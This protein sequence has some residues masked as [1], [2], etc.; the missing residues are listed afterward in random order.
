MLFGPG[1]EETLGRVSFAALLIACGLAAWAMQMLAGPASIAPTL[2]ASGAVLAVVGAY[3]LLR[4]HAH[5]LAVAPVPALGT[6]LEIPAPALIAAWL[7]VQVLLGAA[8]LDEPLAAGTGASWF[9]HLGALALGAAWAALVAR[10]RTSAVP[11]PDRA[12]A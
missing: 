10:R 6:V 9:A 2:G 12:V 11:A 7:A 3:L 8:G 1:V 4:P 5:I